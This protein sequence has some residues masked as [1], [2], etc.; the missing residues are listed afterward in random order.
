MPRYKVIEFF[1]QAEVRVVHEV[2]ADDEEE[3]KHHVN[4]LA[5]LSVLRID[6]GGEAWTESV[7]LL[8]E[9]P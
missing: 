7:E 3:A 1:P 9:A 4:E 6:Y 8:D 2:D 5:D